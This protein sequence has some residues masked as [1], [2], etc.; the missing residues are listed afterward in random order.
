MI[1]DID[2]KKLKKVFVTKEDL[3]KELKN[4]A[5]KEDLKKE[6]K[7]LDRKIDLSIYEVIKF[8]VI[9]FVGEVKDEIIEQLNEFR[10]EM[11]DIS[12]RHEEKLNNHEVRIN[13]IEYANKPS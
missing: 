2:I 7:S 4:Y 12:R 9:K 13:R 11:R 10:Y 8:E 5:T 1:T 6:I 3:R